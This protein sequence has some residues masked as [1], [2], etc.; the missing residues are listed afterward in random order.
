MPVFIPSDGYRN[1]RQGQNRTWESLSSTYPEA[2]WVNP[3]FYIYQEMYDKQLLRGENRVAWRFTM[4]TNGVK[5]A[6]MVGEETMLSLSAGSWGSQVALLWKGLEEDLIKNGWQM[7]NAG[8]KKLFV[9]WEPII[10]IPW[11]DCL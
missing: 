1:S 9:F 8:E 3:F 2:L 10:T 5:C 4:T 7:S 11:N 6:A